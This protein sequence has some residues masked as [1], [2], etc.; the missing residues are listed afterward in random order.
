MTDILDRAMPG[1]DY[2]DGVAQIARQDARRAADRAKAERDWKAA[3][4][5]AHLTYTHQEQP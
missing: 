2:P 4:A 1:D 5:W 3:R